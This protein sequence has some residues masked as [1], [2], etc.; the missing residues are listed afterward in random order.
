M[1][2]SRRELFVGE[3]R[4]LTLAASC[5]VA[6]AV[7]RK[8]NTTSKRVEGK[9]NVHIVPHTHDDVGWLKT[10]DQYY[11]GANNHIQHAN[12]QSIIDATISS[13]LDNPDRKFIYVE[14]AFFQRWWSEQSPQRQGQ[15][16]QLVSSGQLE[17]INGGWSMHGTVPFPIFTVYALPSSRFLRSPP[18]RPLTCRRSLP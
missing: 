16:R 9:I 2:V 8:Y 12:V 14:Q 11:Y 17:F 6:A 13:L 15:V 1:C 3:M 7:Y 4:A 5:A 18:F 10:V